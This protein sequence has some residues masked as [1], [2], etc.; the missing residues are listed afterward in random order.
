MPD[1]MVVAKDAMEENNDDEDNERLD[2][3]DDAS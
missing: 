1:E 2:A 3:G